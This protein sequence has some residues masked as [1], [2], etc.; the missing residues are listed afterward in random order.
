MESVSEKGQITA[1]SL[2]VS[3]SRVNMIGNAFRYFN[4]GKMIKSVLSWCYGYLYGE[5]QQE[6]SESSVFYQIESSIL[7]GFVSVLSE[8]VRDFDIGGMIKLSLEFM[9]LWSPVRCRY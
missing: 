1:L 3:S 9:V 5:C 6:R 8:I 4:I 7:A 2:S